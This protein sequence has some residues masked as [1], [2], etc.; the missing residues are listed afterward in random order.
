MG[1]VSNLFG[2]RPDATPDASDAN[3]MRQAHAAIRDARAGRIS[4]PQMLRS[5]I[6]AQVIVPLADAP[7]MDGKSITHWKPAIVTSE[8]YAAECGVP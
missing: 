8:R 1:L 6:A 2:R 7:G 5:V 4:V 3:A